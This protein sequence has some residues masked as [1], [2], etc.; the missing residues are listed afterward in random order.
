MNTGLRRRMAIGNL[1]GVRRGSALAA[2]AAAAF[3]LAFGLGALILRPAAAGAGGA[4]S[5]AANGLCDSYAGVPQGSLRHAGMAQIQGGHFMMG[6][7][8]HYAEEALA[9]EVQIHSFWIDQHDVTNAQFER[10][11]VATGY[12]T[13][14]ERVPD[15][16][17]HPDLPPQMRV[18]GSVV[19][20]MGEKGRSGRWRYVAGANWRH[21]QGPDSSISDRP[22]HPVVHIAYEDAEAYARWSGRDLPTEA[23]WEHAARGGLQG[24]PYVW[25]SE[26]T[27][28]GKPMANTWQGP[29]PLVNTGEDGHS[30]NFRCWLLSRQWLWAVRHGGQC[31]AVDGHLV[32]QRPCGQPED[33]P[34]GPNELDS[35]DP[36]QPGTPAKV[37][38]GGS[39]LCAA[40]YCMRYR[41]AARQARETDSGTSHIG[42]R[43]VLNERA[44]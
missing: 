24:Q 28:G 25:G 13:V 36:R 22:A 19:F 3:A 40:N 5:A 44:S 34:I 15:I 37:I 29:F 38:K 9:H 33:N 39:H 2:T 30:R 31:L 11:I 42:F 7:D 41:P 10:F 26:F 8:E 12:V 4:A 17:R 27:P 14:A 35:F 6:S 20:V 23:Q 21:P 32:S 43:T 1:A 16:Q 18:P